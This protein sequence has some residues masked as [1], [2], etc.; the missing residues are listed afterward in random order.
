V[1]TTRPPIIPERVRRIDGQGFAFIP[2][3][4]LRDGFLVSLERDELALYVF[5]VLAGDRNG[6]SFYRYD[7]I[8]SI[9]ERSLDDYIRARNGLI[10]KDLIAFDGTRFQVLSLPERP[11]LRAST[12]L[13]SSDDIAERDPASIRG[14]LL[15]A[16]KRE[17]GDDS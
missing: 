5:L 9:L 10:E 3:R 2:N 12:P 15:D 1:A 4:F 16:L 7:S 17:P 8:C 13:S 14:A 6:V 11:V